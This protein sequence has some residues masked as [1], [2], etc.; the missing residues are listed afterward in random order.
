MSVYDQQDISREI[1]VGRLGDRV[2]SKTTRDCETKGA[3]EWLND[4][5]RGQPNGKY[6]QNDFF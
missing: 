1:I 3:A 5:T 2:F 6:F 4:F